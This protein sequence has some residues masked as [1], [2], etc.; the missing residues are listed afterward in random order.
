MIMDFLDYLKELLSKKIILNPNLL[1]TDKKKEEEAFWSKQSKALRH[2]HNLDRNRESIRQL[3]NAMVRFFGA[4]R[5]A[6]ICSHYHLDLDRLEKRGAAIK[7]R[8]IAKIL[9]GASDIYIQ[10]LEEL[11]EEIK[12]P[13]REIVRH[14]DLSDLRRLR[15]ELFSIHSVQDLNPLQLKRLIGILLP[16]QSY[17]LYTH[18]EILPNPTQLLAYLFHDRLL[19]DMERLELNN[20]AS[21]LTNF[22][23]YAELL[24]KSL[25]YREMEKGTLIPAPTLSGGESGYY[26]VASAIV[27][28]KGMVA[29]GLLPVTR[30]MDN[31]DPILLFRGSLF[32]PSGLDAISS[33]ITDLEKEL[34]RSAYRSGKKGLEAFLHMVEGQQV[35]AMGHSLGGTLA[36]WF[37]SEYGDSV[38][39]LITFNAPGL[40]KEIVQKFAKMA[41]HLKQELAIKVYR[42]KG[43]FIHRA[44]DRHLGQGC[45][46]GRVRIHLTEFYTEQR[47]RK[48]RPHKS[49]GLQKG[50]QGV[51]SRVV[52]EALLDLELSN[53]H[54]YL[55]ERCRKYVG[56]YF[57]YYV[58]KTM[59]FLSRSLWSRSRWSGSSR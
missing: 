23:A 54:R 29:Y 13:A 44:G 3:R 8:H 27:T 56:G 11:L 51:K 32:I 34:G 21:T 57:L 25:A 46:N 38:K 45:G 26:Y 31:L 43:D 1:H 2:K 19:M 15:N 17:P 42:V 58:L 10:D 41:F 49:R 9:T 4:G 30:S 40:P 22:E 18:R 24:C 12:D 35:V 47:Q 59:R 39:E 14:L 37:T 55:I 7:E 5:T 53:H 6:R 52:A 16:S 36:Q 33:Y 20:E 28:G 48:W 50:K